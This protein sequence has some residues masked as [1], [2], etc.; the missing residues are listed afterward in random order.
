M[1][2]IY[3]FSSLF[4]LHVQ[5]EITLGYAG[6]FAVLG[7]S[8]VTN[9]GGTVLTGDLGVYPGTAITGFGSSTD[10]HVLL[11]SI[12]A[13]DPLAAQAHADL[14]TANTALGALSGAMDMSGQD[15]GGKILNAGVYSFSSS[16]GLTGNLTLDGKGKTDGLFVFQIGSTLTTASASVVL[17][18]NGAQAS[19]VYWKVGSSA[20]LG[21]TTAFGGNIIAYASIT[22]T[23]GVTN[24]GGLYALTAAVTLD[25][26]VILRASSV[27]ST[28]S[29][30]AANPPP[31]S[32][33]TLPG[34]LST[35]TISETQTQTQP[36]ELTTIVLPA[37]TTSLQGVIT[38]VIE[39]PVT[40]TLYIS[41][42][43]TQTQDGQITTL[44]GSLTTVTNP[45]STTVCSTSTLIKS[46]QVSIKTSVVTSSVSSLVR[47]TVTALGKV[48]TV[49]QTQTVTGLASTQ[50]IAVQTITITTSKSSSKCS[51]TPKTTLMTSTTTPPSSPTTTRVSKRAIGKAFQA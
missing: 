36:G 8:T 43:L 14:E 50:T 33:L 30:P 4:F 7:A 39:P 34:G 42:T 11:G 28:F 15:L 5:A 32:T 13:G 10:G 17:L 18:I 12:H 3:L 22:A 2:L 35:I 29:D 49:F 44:Q 16:V 46:G 26:N 45:A 37:S 20:T 31:C 41:T 24:D 19:N 51:T 9:T 25:T 1:H 40:Q 47:T 48:S 6:T 23:T 27:V 21:T 38:T